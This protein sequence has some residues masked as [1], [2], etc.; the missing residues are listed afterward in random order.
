MPKFRTMKVDT[1]DIFTLMNNPKD[2]ITKLVKKTSLDEVPQIYS[3][4]MNQ[5]ISLVLD[6]HFITI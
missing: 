2:K 5:I 4:I 6:Q 1:K 3:I